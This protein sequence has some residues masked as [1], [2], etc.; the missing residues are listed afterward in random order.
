MLVTIAEAAGNDVTRRAG[1]EN[2]QPVYDT[3]RDKVHIR[4]IVDSV[5]LHW[6]YTLVLET[7]GSAGAGSGDPRTNRGRR[8]TAY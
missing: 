7:G 2:R 4:I 8:T 5:A 6:V 3:V 1:D